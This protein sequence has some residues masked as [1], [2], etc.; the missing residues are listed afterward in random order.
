MDRDILIVGA[1]A[2]GLAAARKLRA[3]GADVLILEACK[4]IGGR[5]YTIHDFASAEPAE[6]GAEFV[7]G[8]PAEIHTLAEEASV[9]LERVE[10]SDLSFD[11]EHF[12]E[13]RDVEADLE[14]LLEGER[15]KKDRPFEEALQASG[16]DDG[17]QTGLRNYIEGFNAAHAARI[18]VQSLLRQQEVEGGDVAR[19]AGGYDAIPR[20]L[21]AGLDVRLHSAVDSI[22]W[23]RGAVEVRAGEE[24]WHARQVL[25]TVSLGVLQAGTIRFDPEPRASLDAARSLAMGA[26]VRLTMRFDERVW[27]RHGKLATASFLHTPSEPFTA[28]WPRGQ[29]ITA[30]AGGAQADR[31]PSRDRSALTE[32]ALDTLVKITG[33]SLDNLRSNL[34]AVHYLDWSANQFTR[35]A[36]SYVPAGAIEAP[37][38]LAQAVEDTIYFAGEAV[39]ESAECGTVQAAIRSGERAAQAML[40]AR[41]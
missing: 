5:I 1:G 20:L 10:G 15:G 13:G 40:A 11:G 39:G 27:M 17:A 34:A 31:L 12:A 23:R 21:G 33:E 26:A 9:S 16:L 36:Y 29:M 22:Q 24:R 4:H 6:L 28:W 25:V 38:I 19:I 7:H 3:A 8:S 14:R 37:S 18:S 30:W 32:L 2:A 41:D 35:G